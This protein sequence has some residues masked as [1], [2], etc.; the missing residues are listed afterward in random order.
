[1]QPGAAGLVKYAAYGQRAFAFFIQA[2]GAANVSRD[3]VVALI[4]GYA[5]FAGVGHVAGNGRTVV[6]RG[7]AGQNT[8]IRHAELTAVLHHGVVGDAVRRHG[9][10]TAAFQQQVVCELIG[11]RELTQR[12][13]AVNRGVG[14][15][16]NARAAVQV[17][18]GRLGLI[19]HG[20]HTALVNDGLVGHAAFTDILH[21]AFGHR[22][23]D[24]GAAERHALAAI[25]ADG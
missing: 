25:F 2:T 14:A 6:Q 7:G 9:E 4:G 11:D 23:R 24:C 3:G 18:V 5:Q 17:D 21:A 15:G 10:Q 20:Q 8:A 16:D 1:M 12:V 22:G 13:R 19:R